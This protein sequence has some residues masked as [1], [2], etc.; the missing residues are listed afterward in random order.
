MVLHKLPIVVLGLTIIASLG[1]CCTSGA[2]GSGS[3]T[4]SSEQIYPAP[5]AAP[6]S[7]CGCSAASDSAMSYVSSDSMMGDG[8]SPTA[9]V[10]ELPSFNG[11]SGFTAGSAS[12][13]NELP[14]NLLP[15]N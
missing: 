8:Y 9:P 13:A 2:C 7:S 15:A 5:T 6:V 4:T 11:V 1:G 12:K 14:G 3:C 10:V